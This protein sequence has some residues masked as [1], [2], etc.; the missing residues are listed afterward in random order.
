MLSTT[1]R[2]RNDNTIYFEAS[3]RKADGTLSDAVTPAYLIENSKGTS[4]A[5]GTPTKKSTGIYYFF[6]TPDT[7]GDF[8]V[9]FSGTIETLAAVMRKKFKIYED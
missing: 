1:R 4:Q 6:Y 7:V 2:F 8:V 3:F 9:E 5:S